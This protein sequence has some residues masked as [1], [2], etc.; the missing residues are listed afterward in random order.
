MQ[1]IYLL[2]ILTFLS[3]CVAPRSNPSASVSTFEAGIKVASDKYR[4][5]IQYYADYWF[6]G[7]SKKKILNRDEQFVN[8]RTVKKAHLVYYA[9]TIVEPY[10]STLGLIYPGKSVQEIVPV[11]L[12][13]L[14]SRHA[15]NV[16]SNEQ[17]IGLNNF[18]KI[19]Y[20]TKH[21]DLRIGIKYLEYICPAGSHTLR[22]VFWTT[23]A[24]DTWLE[25]EA[26]AIVSSL[27]T[28]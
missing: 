7:W 25:E 15:I 8:S 4:F 3:S 11:I 14:K 26:Q 21:A 13:E 24:G 6:H 22:I 5:S 20:E 10:C 1:K 17:L 9:H 28:P 18:T 27:Q 2:S 19:S 23:E 16:L 12:N